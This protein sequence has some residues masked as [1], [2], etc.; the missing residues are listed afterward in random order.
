MSKIP[1]REIQIKLEI[2]INNEVKHLFIIVSNNK[3]YP[4]RENMD[5]LKESA[6]ELQTIIMAF[7][8]NEMMDAVFGGVFDEDS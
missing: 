1:K 6:E 7:Q 2:S 5:I 4:D 8:H 3:G